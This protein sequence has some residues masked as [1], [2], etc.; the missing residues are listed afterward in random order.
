RSRFCKRPSATLA[1]RVHQCLDGHGGCGQ[2]LGTLEGHQTPAGPLL[3]PP[4]LIPKLIDLAGKLVRLA[5]LMYRD[6]VHDAAPSSPVSAASNLRRDAT[7]R[8]PIRLAGT[9]PLASRWY[10]ARSVWPIA[11]AIASAP[12]MTSEAVVSS[13]VVILTLR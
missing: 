1:Q 2:G 12:Q 6:D 13:I 3:V 8:P 10:V 11:F 9:S 7:H 5:R 4:H